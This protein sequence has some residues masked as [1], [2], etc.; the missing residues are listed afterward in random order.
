M[1]TDT[2]KTFSFKS[3][4]VEEM[5]KQMKFART[6]LLTLVL[7]VLLGLGSGGV[8]RVYATDF[9]SGTEQEGSQNSGSEETYNNGISNWVQGYDPVTD[10]NMAVA[11]KQTSW[12]QTLVGNI[13]GI[14]IIGLFLALSAMTV[15]DLIAIVAT[16]IRPNLLGQ[17]ASGRQYVSDECMRAITE[18]VGGAPAGGMGSPM[19]GMGMGSPMSMGGMNRMGGMGMGSPMGMGGMGSPMG[20]MN[21]MQQQ[22]AGQ[23]R[24]NTVLSYFKY[25]IFAIVLIAICAVVLTSSVI[26]GCGINIAQLF[27][28][29]IAGLNF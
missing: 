23:G 21:N 1:Q 16:P 24:K 9:P 2:Q 3:K 11:N 27:L 4:G 26:T 7:A 13:I 19:G 25:R 14:G 17:N 22:G 10:E 18:S 12:L 5:K 8:N 29:I 6:V 20:G 15:I 28:R